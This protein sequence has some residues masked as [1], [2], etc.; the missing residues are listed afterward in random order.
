MCLKPQPPRLM[1]PELAAWGANHLADDDPYKLVG[2]TLYEQYH[3]EDFADLY[4]NEGKPAL[5]P[6]LLSFVT[7][8]QGFDNLPDRKA[9]EAVEVNLKWKYALHLPLDAGSFDSSVLC[10]F[11][12]RLL[13]HSAEAQVFDQVLT[14]LKALAWSKHAAFSAATAWRCSAA[15]ANWGGSNWSS[16]LCA[17]RCATC[18]SWRGTG[19]ARSSPPSG[20]NAITTT[21]GPSAR[22]TRSA[23]RSRSSSATTGSGCS[24]DWMPMIH[25]MV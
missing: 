8:F 14:Q 23:R 6:V 25:Q 3:D 4:H 11:R 24:R 18:S 1:P 19:C 17:W 12:K 9:A 10:E 7:V 5:S 13:K 16:R 15:P 22:A 2:D 21:A 20:H